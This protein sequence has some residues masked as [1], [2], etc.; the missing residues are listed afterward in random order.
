[1]YVGMVCMYVGMLCMYVGMLCPMNVINMLEMLCPRV[2]APLSLAM[3]LYKSRICGQ[4]QHS[5]LIIPRPSHVT[6]CLAHPS[7]RLLF[8]L[9]CSQFRYEV[10]VPTHYEAG[11]IFFSAAI[12]NGTTYQNNSIVL[13]EDIGEDDDALLC[14]T[15]QTACCRSEDTG[16]P[17]LG[18]W[19]FPNGTT[20]PSYTATSGEESNFYGTRGQMVVR[21]NR[22]RGGV[23]GIYRC[24]IPAAMNIT[25]TKYIGVYSANTGECS[26]LFWSYYSAYVAKAR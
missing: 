10:N 9:A 5:S 12:L 16:G 1:M 17:A 7:R 24:V 23:E 4:Q 14:I 20:V 21:M 26:I 15:N 18:K 22:R 11:N 3:S 13:L 6:L 2:P 25:Q 8:L 19:F